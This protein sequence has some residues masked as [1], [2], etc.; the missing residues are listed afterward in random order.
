MLDYQQGRNIILAL[1][2]NN[3]EV[4]AE[5]IE[6]ALREKKLI[7]ENNTSGWPRH[8]Y[9]DP[10]LRTREIIRTRRG[11]YD[12]GRSINENTIS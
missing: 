6:R 4:K 5:D 7:P 12:M 8:R 2:R 9:L 1:V 3:G 11:Y 10:L